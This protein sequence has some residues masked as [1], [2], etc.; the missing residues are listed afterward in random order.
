MKGQQNGDMGFTVERSTD[1]TWSVTLPHSCSEWTI[2]NDGEWEPVPH[3]QA[4]KELE[5]FIAQAQAALTKLKNR[6]E[7]GID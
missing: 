3:E 1:D 2:T 4:V 7:Q 6:E 5:S